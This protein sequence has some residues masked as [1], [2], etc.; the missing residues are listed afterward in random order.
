MRSAD[1]GALAEAWDGAFAAA[2]LPRLA[3]ERVAALGGGSPEE[4][5]AQLRRGVAQE[6]AALA[7]AAAI[8]LGELGGESGKA[9]AYQL[10][11][12]LLNEFEP[13][14]QALRARVDE[15][16]SL[17]PIDEWRAW[18]SVRALALEAV[19]LTGQEGHRQVFRSLNTT[20]SRARRRGSTTSGARTTSPTSSIGVCS[21]RPS[22]W[23]ATP[24]SSDSRRTCRWGRSAVNVHIWQ[25]RS[26]LSER[27]RR[28]RDE[29]FSF[30]TRDFRNEVMAFTTGTPWDDVYSPAPLGVVPEVYAFL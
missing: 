8:P 18:V 9:A 5:C 10:R 22:R 17:P 2:D 24:P 3:A 11:A 4:A 30:E 19:R 29:Y 6:I 13:A 27:V 15:Q 14:I 28:L 16:R 25:P 21:R 26:T 7:R 1:L 20:G 12:A 23:A